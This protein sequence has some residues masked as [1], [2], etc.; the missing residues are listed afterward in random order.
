M[1]CTIRTEADFL[2]W[3]EKWYLRFRAGVVQKETG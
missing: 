2:T 3:A 1:L